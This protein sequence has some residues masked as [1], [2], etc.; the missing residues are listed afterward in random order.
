M[1]SLVKKEFGRRLKAARKESGFTQTRLGELLGGLDFTTVSRWESGRFSPD[2]AHFA[3]I[4][5][6]LNKPADYF[7]GAPAPL[8]KTVEQLTRV[9]EDQ[10]RRI[11]DLEA[12]KS[13]TLKAEQVELLALL[14]GLDE[15]KAS[16]LLRFARRLAGVQ[17][18]FDLKKG[19][20]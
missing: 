20:K 16:G 19:G 5:R 13:A 4:C 9:I 14:A 8:P 12:A 18:G 10:E 11:R 6:V 17:K 15:H 3:D 7:T 1:K 2:E